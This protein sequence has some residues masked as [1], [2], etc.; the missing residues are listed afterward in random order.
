MRLHPL[1]LVT[2]RTARARLSIRV[3]K[4]GHVGGMLSRKTWKL[5]LFLK[6]TGPAFVSCDPLRN[7]SWKQLVQNYGDKST[8]PSEARSRSYSPGDTWPRLP[9]IIVLTLADCPWVMQVG[10]RI[11]GSALGS[12]YNW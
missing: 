10:E 4:G 5:G 12:V 2:E 1:A 3:V 7:Y 11:R 6:V 8:S 9:R